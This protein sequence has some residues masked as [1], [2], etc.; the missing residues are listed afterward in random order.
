MG[1]APCHLCL[2]QRWPHFAAVAA[3]SIGLLIGADTRLGRLCIAIAA[4]G[5][6][7][8]GGIAVFHAGVEAGL[9]EYISPCTSGMATGGNVLEAIMAAPL[10]R[11]DEVAFRFL[12][13]SMAGWNAIVSLATAATLVFLL[14][15]RKL[16]EQHADAHP[17]MSS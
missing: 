2:L 10:V 1:L 5:I 15:R 17:M 12:G 9:W 14:S 16:S 8:S 3:G 7:T 4:G 11:C 6:A 13:I